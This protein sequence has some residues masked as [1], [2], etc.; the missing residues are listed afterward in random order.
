MVLAELSPSG[1]EDGVGRSTKMLGVRGPR[2][3]FRGEN[4]D[5]LVEVADGGGDFSLGDVGQCGVFSPG[6][7]LLVF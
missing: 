1:V 3:G 6:V 7:A 5:G 2:S 4:T